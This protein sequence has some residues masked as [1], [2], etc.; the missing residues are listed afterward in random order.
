LPAGQA[1]QVVAP[2]L[3]NVPA[4]HAQSAP[5]PQ[6]TFTPLNVPLNVVVGRPRLVVEPAG[7][8]NPAAHSLLAF[9]APVAQNLPAG[10]V[11][12]LDSPCVEKEPAAHRTGWSVPPAQLDPA[13][14]GEH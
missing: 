9:C 10:H 6:E 4:G 2:A 11:R 13:G 1:V 14:H 7:Q 5:E 3:L 12:Q 8:K